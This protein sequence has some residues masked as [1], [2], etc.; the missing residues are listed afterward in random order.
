MPSAY[1][2][3]LCCL[4]YFRHSCVSLIPTHPS[5]LSLLKSDISRH[6]R[7]HPYYRNNHNENQTLIYLVLFR[8]VSPSR[9]QAPEGRYFTHLVLSLVPGP[10]HKSERW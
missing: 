4:R 3:F 6:S 10:W 5:G 9:T 1:I 8:V 7:P 2:R